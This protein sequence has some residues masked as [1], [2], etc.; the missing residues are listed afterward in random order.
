MYSFG[1]DVSRMCVMLAS[2]G[3]GTGGSVGVFV[4]GA[5]LVASL[6]GIIHR[7]VLVHLCPQMIDFPLYFIVHPILLKITSHPALQ[8]LTTEMSECDARCGSTCA[9]RARSGKWLSCNVHVCVVQIVSPFGNFAR[10]GIVA[11]CMLLKGAAVVRKWLLAPESTMAQ[12]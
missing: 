12:S 1:V 9:C 5:R 4:G 11:V 3:N 6:S 10:I 2:S 7:P 8:R